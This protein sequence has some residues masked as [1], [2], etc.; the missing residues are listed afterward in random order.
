M[1]PLCPAPD[2]RTLPTGNISSSIPQQIGNLTALTSLRITNGVTGGIPKSLSSLQSLSFLDLHK[3]AMKGTLDVPCGALRELTTLALNGNRFTGKVPSTLSL[4]RKLQ[5]LLLG[6]NRLSGTIPDIFTGLEDLR[7]LDLS[8]NYLSGTVPASLANLSDL[9]FLDLSSNQLTGPAPTQLASGAMGTSDSTYRVS[10]NFFSGSPVTSASGNLFCPPYL[11]GGYAFAILAAFGSSP[12]SSSSGNCFNTSGDPWQ[13]YTRGDEDGP[14]NYTK[15]LEADKED[16][17]MYL[18]QEGNLSALLRGPWGR[19]RKDGSSDDGFRAAAARK[20]S[21][22]W[23]GGVFASKAQARKG[24]APTYPA[25]CYVE[26]QKS[27]QLCAAFCNAGDPK[28]PCAGL[29]TCSLSSP[30]S[31]EPKCT[32]VASYATYISTSTVPWLDSVSRQAV[33]YFPSCTTDQSQ[34]EVQDK[35]GAGL[36]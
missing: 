25:A 1:T 11:Q 10:N 33:P 31:F 7:A 14:S 15:Y 19:G 8:S 17:L 23:S 27:A 9:V 28:P 16:G 6:N 22:S 12:L 5:N 3:N 30:S 35:D 4:C 2:C 32:C 29:G 21:K 26:P 34:G 13:G 20:G 36:G 18:F 24:T